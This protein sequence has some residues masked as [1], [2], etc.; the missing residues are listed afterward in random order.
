MPHGEGVG[1]SSPTTNEG[2]V[3]IV[4]LQD[5]EEGA[6]SYMRGET[7][8]VD[9]KTYGAPYRILARKQTEQP[10]ETTNPHTRQQVA[11]PDRTRVKALTLL[12]FPLNQ[13]LTL[14]APIPTM[15]TN[16]P[17]VLWQGRLAD[18]ESSDGFFG[19]QR[20]I[21]R[22]L[23][24]FVDV[25]VLHTDAMGVASWRESR[26]EHF[27]NEVAILKQAVEAMSDELAILR[28]DPPFPAS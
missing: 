7:V 19:P 22:G 6:K 12:L 27:Q 15:T 16:Q 11:R 2:G 28:D 9:L 8:L 1:Q 10:N 18:E 24:G 13:R 20:R 4:A 26:S 21:V 25:E 3:E 14:L 23:S 5:S 17:R